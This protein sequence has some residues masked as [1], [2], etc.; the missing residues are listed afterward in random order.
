MAHQ[1]S[2]PKHGTP[3]PDYF[4]C[5]PPDD[6]QIRSSTWGCVTNNTW[7]V[8]TSR[9]C[10]QQCANAIVTPKDT[11]QARNTFTQRNKRLYARLMSYLSKNQSSVIS[12]E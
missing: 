1:G 4:L 9:Q 2:S 10:Q 7:L 12:N 8:V 6:E 5:F 11:R 3:S